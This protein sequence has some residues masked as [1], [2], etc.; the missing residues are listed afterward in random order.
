MARPSVRTFESYQHILR[1]RYR[2][3]NFASRSL[4]L[5]SSKRP[6]HAY[7]H[8]PICR[9]LQRILLCSFRSRYP[10]SFVWSYSKRNC[11]IRIPTKHAPSPNFQ[12]Q[13]SSLIK[14]L[15]ITLRIGTFISEDQ[16]WS[17][18]MLKYPLLP[19]IKSTTPIEQL[20][21]IRGYIQKHRLTMYTNPGRIFCIAS[22]S[23]LANTNHI[24]SLDIVDF[25]K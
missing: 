9:T 11:F 4:P 8:S 3:H 16:T 15:S 25:H 21:L 7:I 14:P 19:M 6:R 13:L 5:S 17:I 18:S 20:H 22:K 1:S 10:K 23:N 12:P 2:S 24:N